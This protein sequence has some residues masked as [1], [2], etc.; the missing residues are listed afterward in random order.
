[1]QKWVS[2]ATER[3]TAFQEK[4]QEHKKSINYCSVIYNYTHVEYSQKLKNFKPT[5]NNIAYILYQ[6]IITKI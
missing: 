6:L 1:M 5:I 4:G 2:L 3:Q